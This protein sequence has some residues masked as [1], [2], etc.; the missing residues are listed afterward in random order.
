MLLIVN[1]QVCHGRTWSLHFEYR[2][3]YSL[4]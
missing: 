1:I 2:T 4:V 3:F